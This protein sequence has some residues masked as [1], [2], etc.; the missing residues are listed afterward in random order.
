MEFEEEAGLSAEANLGV[1]PMNPP[2]AQ[3]LEYN[4]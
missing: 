2:M 3:N 4:E 1:D